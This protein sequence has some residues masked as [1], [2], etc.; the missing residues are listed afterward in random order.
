MRGEMEWGRPG[1]GTLSVRRTE[2]HCRSAFQ[3]DGVHDGRN[4]KNE[5]RVHKLANQSKCG[6][7]ENHAHPS[8]AATQEGQEEAR[9]EKGD[10]KEGRGL[11]ATQVSRKV[12]CNKSITDADS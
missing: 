9:E 4:T 1:W 3:A 10:K 6:L 5:K 7:G 2:R 11:R 8:L 12:R